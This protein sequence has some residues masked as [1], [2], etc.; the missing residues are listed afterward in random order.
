MLKKIIKLNE[1]QIKDEQQ[2]ISEDFNENP[3]IKAAL[4]LLKESNY[5]KAEL[6]TYDR[7]WDSISSEK[8]LV[9]G[10]FD[11]GKIEGKIEGKL[12]GKIEIAKILKAKGMD[13]TFIIETTGLSE[14]EI[15]KL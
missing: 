12:E 1:R 9:L 7:Y 6:E 5:T 11:E 13:V 14:D 4:E 2:E 10:A 8:T 3:F 15:E